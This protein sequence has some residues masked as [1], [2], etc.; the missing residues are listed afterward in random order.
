[1]AGV[2]FWDHKAHSRTFIPHLKPPKDILPS[3]LR[4][5]KMH[6]MESP[7]SLG[8]PS[9]MYQEREGGFELSYIR[10]P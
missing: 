7:S 10:A 9:T 3:L 4:T 5:S 8:S 2:T 1:M 6:T